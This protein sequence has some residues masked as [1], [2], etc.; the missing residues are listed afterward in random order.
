MKYYFYNKIISA[1][2][3]LSLMFSSSISSAHS[4][5]GENDLTKLIEELSTKV[6]IS[7]KQKTVREIIYII[8]K[9]SN[10][11]IVIQ[12]EDIDKL[13]KIDFSVTNVTA[14][15]ALGQL[16]KNTPYVFKVKNG[17]VAITK[18]VEES[19][20]VEPE[21]MMTIKGKVIDKD[22]K[23]PIT[24]ATIIVV[25]TTDGAIT[26]NNGA[27]VLNAYPSNLLEI[28]YLGYKTVI[29]SENGGNKKEIVIEMKTDAMSVD[30]VVVMGMFNRRK[31]GFTGSAT[32]VK[33]E[34]IMKISS[35]NVLKALEMMDPS[36]TIGTSNL[37]GS[38]PNAMADFGVRGKSNMGNYEAADAV[39]LR[40]D[41][42]TR[43][44]QP[45]FVLDGVIGVEASAVTDLD[46]SQ[47]ESITLLKDAA[48]TVI[49]GSK[50]ANGVVVVETKAPEMGKLRV[51]YNGNYSIQIPDL[52]DYN[53][54]NSSEKIQIEE[55]AGLYDDKNDM[56]QNNYYNHINNEVARGV[57]TYWLS[58]PV[59][60]AVGHR[61]G[62][63]LEGGDNS[64]RYKIYMG[65]NS[66]PG[67]MKDT[68]L[69]TK[70][71]KIDLRYRF[72]K[73][74]ISNQ[75]HINYTDGRR[76]S[77]YGNFSDY[78]SLNPY[79]RIYDENG[80][81]AENLENPGI[82]SNKKVGNPMHNTTFASK[83][84]LKEFSLLES[85]KAEYNPIEGLRFSLD[86][87]LSDR[88][89]SV[90]VFKPAMHTDFINTTDPALQGSYDKS[91]S[92]AFN[93]VLSVT[94]SYNKVIKQ[95]HILSVIARY[96]VSED[97]S[98]SSMINMLGF[99]SDK[100]SEVYLGTSYDA[101][102]GDENISRSIGMLL[103]TNYSYKNK[104][105]ADFSIR[106]DASSQFGESSRFAPF[107]SLGGRWN[108]GN[109]KFIKR[110]N[111]FDDLSLSATYGIT[112][113]QDFSSYQSLQ[114]YSYDGLTDYYKSSDVIGAQL[115]GL[116]NPNLKWQHTDNYN[117]SLNTV[118]FNNIVSA[119]FEYYEK[120][121]QNTLL[122]YSLAPSTGFSTIKDNLGKISNKGYEASLRI[123]PYN[124][125]KQEAYWSFT[126]TA[127]RNESII[128]EISN[129]MNANNEKSMLDSRLSSV[130]LPKY[131]NGYSQTMYW[132]VQSL[133]ID[134]STGKEL[135]LNRDG[136]T[137]YTRDVTQ[138]VPVADTAPTMQG[139]ISTSFGYKGFGINLSTRYQFG[140]YIYNETLLNKIENADLYGNVD[141]R[142]LTDRWREPGDIA[143]YRALDKDVSMNN[144][145]SSSRFVEIDN[146]FIMSSLN[147]SY[148]MN[149]EKNKFL[150]KL[151]LSTATI[152]LYFEDMAQF[153]TV[154]MER[155]IDYPFAQKISLSLNLIF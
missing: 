28:S 102:S 70:S 43:P 84:D 39:V 143:Q 104:Y 57:D 46:P 121:T 19:S 12:D 10:L 44:N 122:D 90:D 52:R 112:G 85:F 145:N 79:Y 30:D 47:V 51:S 95:D 74:L 14:V 155:G 21:K 63:N 82:E 38:N 93:Y 149:K 40:G 36:F 76:T 132:A 139:A 89:G 49:Y 53:L 69:N 9:K 23:K 135:F 110:L 118:M 148:N 91:N 20:E 115:Y 29:Y 3:V 100:L 42:N 75:L 137:T 22:S 1:F 96:E 18:R 107:W 80:K 151:G 56:T 141:K 92:D 59:R 105:S 48:A 83:D 81:I 99:P 15:D 11:N 55:L 111:I 109:E 140:G 147:I 31:E 8:Q 133:G 126:F 2:I 134:P 67:V 68:D 66:S 146:Q 97:S 54:T 86:F 24:G 131:V 50:A 62:I 106:V 5:R 113:S 116:G 26:A 114:M 58:Q 101:I 17:N 127:G 87:T 71:G 124:N 129:A 72:G 13:P 32:V 88:N 117:I 150:G 4:V 144:T 142:A 119:K 7:V 138:E 6:T 94:G 33:S 27:F 103:S 64:L 37:S 130:P 41:V 73:F 25:G 154:K 123:M 65:F 108:I 136:S 128:E 153:T 34:D 61:H 45:L 16:L 120:Y 152:N 125:I 35:G 60:T 78:A 98:N 77:P